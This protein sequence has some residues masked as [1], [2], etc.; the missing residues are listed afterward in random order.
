MIIIQEKIV[1]KDILKEQFL[2]NLN[3][4]KGACCWEGD[5]GAPLTKEEILTLERIY[6][7]VKPFLTE[8]GKAVIAEEGLF[9]YYKG[10]NDYGTTLLKSGACTF[11]IKNEDGI[12]LC[13][14]EQAHKA[15]AT[16]FYKPISCHLYPIRAE[17][18][19]NNGMEIL[20]Y[21][22]WDICSAACTLGKKEELPVY[23]FL[24]NAIV[25]KYGED[26]YEELDAAAQHLKEMEKT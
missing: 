7:D 15:G 5:Y 12:A 1:Q 11:L 25:R 18:N 2:C 16:D 19:H 8:E 10:M 24:K 21:D 20:E 26:F 14:L 23:K 17:E 22:R 3:A 4:C 6:D 13:G 9:K